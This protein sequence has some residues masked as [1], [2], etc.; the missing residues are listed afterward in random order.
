MKMTTKKI[1][2]VFCLTC[3]FWGAASLKTN[4]Q[5]GVRVSFGV[6][7]DNL[8]PYGQW[9]ED[10]AY[11]YVWIPSVEHGFRPYFS[12]GHWVMTEYGNMW[13]SEYPW[14]WAPF[15]YG[16][17]T[18]NS[19]YGWLWIPD[20]EWGP[21][22]V[23]WRSSPD[24][25]GWAPIGP[26]IS[27]SMSFGG[28]NP[29]VD[30]WVFVGPSYI[31]E[32]SLRRYYN[33]PR[34]NTT[35]IQN[36]TIINNTYVNNQRT[37]ISGPRADEV[38]RIT[39]KNV[40]V[41]K[42]G[43]ESKPGVASVQDNTVRVY[44]PAVEKSGKDIAPPKV[45][46]AERPI[47]KPEPVESG[48]KTAP[49]QKQGE[50]PARNEKSSPEIKRGSEKQKVQPSP[51]HGQ[52]VREQ[53]KREITPGKQNTQPSREQP[54]REVTP[55]PE[56]KERSSP[57]QQQ[58]RQM[59]FPVQ[60]HEQPAKEQPQREMKPAPEQRERPHQRDDNPPAPKQQT[61]KQM[62]SEPHLQQRPHGLRRARSLRLL[63]P[64]WLDPTT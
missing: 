40:P 64:Q 55:M 5:I 36:T 29:P 63:P 54:K 14:G 35:I 56:K 44:R 23:S 57:K 62:P 28:Y 60:K 3:L 47:G 52:P 42:V 53:Q 48:S 2:F 38:Q 1:I 16:R 20:N 19:F 6:F 59:E 34:S 51:K 7:Y 15:H 8:S 58:K 10:P 24:Y 13:V 37:Y 30:W 12:S 21:A 41:Y 49:W 25:F 32:P 31:Y 61:E 11:G 39:H 33:G 17:W 18:Y 50:T 26:G 9:I 4:A 22:W 46:K 27:I 43:N 45:R